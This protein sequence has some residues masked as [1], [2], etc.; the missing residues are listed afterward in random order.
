MAKRRPARRGTPSHPGPGFQPE[1]L[2][3][4][5]ELR[6]FTRRW[7]QLKL[8]D[9]DLQALQILIMTRP[10]VG[11]VIEGTGGLR[12]MRFARL[13]GDTGKSG[14]LRVCYAYFEPVATIV[15][16]IVYQKGEQDDLTAA[17]KAALRSAV[18]RVERSLM[19]RPYRSTP[20][21]GAD[22]R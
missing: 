5:I 6:P 4:F 10:H 22:D 15:L 18:A 8:T 2:L 20:R 11:T 16:A 21:P 1:D 14:G 19:S 12:K 17:D 7:Q 13:H 9:A 3:T